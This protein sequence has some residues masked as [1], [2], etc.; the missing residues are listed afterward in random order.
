MMTAIRKTCNIILDFLNKSY[1][2]FFG[3]SAFEVK[4]GSMKPTIS[5]SDVIIVKNEKNPNVNDIITY[6]NNN[7]FITHRVVEKSGNNYITKGDA[8]NTRDNAITS[9]DVVGK[10]VHVLPKFGIIRKTILN[11]FVIITLIITIFGVHT[12]FNKKKILKFSVDKKELEDSVPM[13]IEASNEDEEDASDIDDD[14]IEIKQITE[15][16]IEESADLKNEPV[17]EED[18]EKT[19]IFRKISV[20]AEDLN[21]PTIVDDEDEEELAEEVSEEIENVDEEKNIESKLKVTTITDI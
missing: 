21:P 9:D 16:L 2:S 11:P 13:K 8:N 4:T 6:K 1:S 10:V 5:P 3:Y 12:L 14:P 19:M 15:E 7:D 20:D 18:L 17:I